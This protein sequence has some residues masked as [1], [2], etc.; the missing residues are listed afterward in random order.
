MI[1]LLILFIISKHE[2]SMYGIR[3]KILEYF[4]SY[5]KPS[6]GA[7][8]PALRRLEKS[9]CIKS[10]KTLSEGGKQFGFYSITEK[11]ITE[12]KN[13]I[14]RDI[15]DNPLQFFTNA[16]IK[17]SCASILDNNDVQKL[18]LNLKT[19]AFTLKNT[20]ESILNKDKNNLSFYQR[21]MLD[22]TICEYQNFIQTV[23]LLENKNNDGNS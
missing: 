22:N 5:T 15:S 16:R 3:K 10:G 12:L 14:L 2:T 13:I 18:C 23:E 8:K 7:I 4:G 1:E 11:G 19:Q 17:I 20:A 21:I 9:E 6:F